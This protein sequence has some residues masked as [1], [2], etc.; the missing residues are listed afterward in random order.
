MINYGYINDQAKFI[1]S[2]PILQTSLNLVIL[3]KNDCDFR[4]KKMFQ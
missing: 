4:E 1:E 2:R 3:R